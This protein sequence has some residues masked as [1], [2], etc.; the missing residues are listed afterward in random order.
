MRIFT[1]T[2]F[3]GH[4]PVGTA[5][6]VIAETRQD[7]KTYLDD[8]LV[9]AGLEPCDAEGFIELPYVEGQASILCDGNY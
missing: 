2:N 6:V 5:A 8:Q 9:N 4:Y 3:T 1:H 7:A